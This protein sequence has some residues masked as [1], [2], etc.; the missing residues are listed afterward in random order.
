MSVVNDHVAYAT[1]D[2]IKDDIL[3]LS[4]QIEH[5]FNNLNETNARLNTIELKLNSARKIIRSLE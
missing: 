5:L 4:N 2:D 3:A 1:K